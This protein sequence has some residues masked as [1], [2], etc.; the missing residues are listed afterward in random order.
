MLPNWAE[1]TTTGSPGPEANTFALYGDV[2]SVSDLVPILAESCGVVDDTAGQN[3]TAT[4]DCTFLGLR[5]GVSSTFIAV[6]VQYY[7]GSSFLLLL[8]GYDNGLPNIET[9][10]SNDTT[11]PVRVRK[12]KKL[13]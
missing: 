12:L 6:A 13:P 11:L 1:E 10:P 8:E 4:P 9:D 7:R 2:A 3:L 5:T